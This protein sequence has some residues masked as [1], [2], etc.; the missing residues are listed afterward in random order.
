MSS[1]YTRGNDQYFYSNK[2]K[3]FPCAYRNSTYD[4]TARL[5]T[6][7]NFTHLPHTADKAS[8]IIKF[9]NE[10]LICVIQGYY[11]EIEIGA[12][13][14]TA[15]QNK[16]LNICVASPNGV[17]SIESPHLC[18]WESINIEDTLDIT[19][20]SNTFFAG[21][22][23]SS[24]KALSKGSYS[25]YAL[26]LDA[27]AKLPIMASKIEDSAEGNAGVPIS[28]KFTTETLSAT[29]SI[30][31][32]SLNVASSQLIANSDNII[33]NVPVTINSTLDVKT[34][35]TSVLKAENNQVIINKPTNI[36]GTTTIKGATQIENSSSEATDGNLKV[37]GTGN[38]GDKLTVASGG[39]EIT[40]ATEIKGGSGNLKVAGI[41][42][43]GGKLTV[44]AGG[45]EI[46]GGTTIYGTTGITGKTTIGSG[47]TKTEIEND[48]IKTSKI[49]IEKA[50]NT[51]SLVINKKQDNII[52]I[53]DKSNTLIFSVNTNSGK[54]YAKE[55]NAGSINATVEGTS[56]DAINVT[57]SINDK[58]ITDI[59]ETNGS[60]ARKASS[61]TAT[62][63][64]NSVG[65]TIITG[66]TTGTV[67]ALIPAKTTGRTYNIGS[68]NETFDNIY[69]TTF[70]GS[71]AGNANTATAFKEAASITLTGDVITSPAATGTHGW[72]VNT[73]IQ[74]DAVTTVKIANSAVTEAKIGGGAVTTS[75]IASSAVTNAKLANSA[76]TTD[77]IFDG[78]VT[79][80]KIADNAVTEAKI[81]AGAVTTSK[82][83]DLNVTNNK[84]ENSSIT[85]GSSSVALGST[86]GSSASRI[87]GTLYVSAIN[88]SGN[89]TANTFNAESDRRLKENIIDYKPE[90]SILDLPIKKFDFIDG[91]KNQIG[92]IAQDLKEICPEIVNENE[93]GYLSIQEN[94]LVYLLLD[95]VK[96]L[97]NEVEKLKHK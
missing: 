3:V 33:A 44:T 84:L 54:T 83:K 96:K 7:Y 14:Y 35:N 75:K 22:K 29:T 9:D 64:N 10:K 60:V 49:T 34:G 65:N 2:I 74:N 48:T 36:T 86:I 90:K 61:I 39:V 56:D 58:L 72:T 89:I 13:D 77:K 70:Y 15:L 69:A 38:F 91:P 88:A 46:A 85:I 94:K 92:C 31:T 17:G 52:E 59:F 78:N 40:G 32:P 95:E 21:L 12:G 4:A 97:K 6:E 79:T 71:L 73:I 62:S 25:C 26:K 87:T 81:G 11:F 28:R 16:Y 66:N 47:D 18:S 93:K 41:G 30:S 27:G 82:I 50:S 76:V 68:S 20:G 55:I 5:N 57:T 53:K 51:G 1:I 63:S 19:K 42:E 37:E 67:D 8:Y 43:F 45:A 80:G 24:G 23:I